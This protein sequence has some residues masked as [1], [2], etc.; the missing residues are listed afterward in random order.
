MQSDLE[1]E[2]DHAQLG[3]GVDH[4]LGRIQK[5]EHGSAENHS[6]NQLSENCGLSRALDE[7]AEELGRGQQRG[8][9]QQQMGEGVSF[10]QESGGS[11]VTG[12]N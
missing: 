4:R 6:G 8:E 9:N 10:G 1:K 7:C 3:Q 5:A 12:P 2:N 11:R